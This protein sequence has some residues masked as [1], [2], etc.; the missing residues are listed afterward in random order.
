MGGHRGEKVCVGVSGAE[1]GRGIRGHAMP[2]PGHFQQHQ[3]VR[4]TRE[5]GWWP[6]YRGV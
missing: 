5:W 6:I 2:S 1:R 3:H 4:K